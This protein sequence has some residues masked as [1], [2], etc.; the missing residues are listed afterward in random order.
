MVLLASEASTRHSNFNRENMFSICGL[1][2]VNSHPTRQNKSHIW[3]ALHL[4]KILNTP[5]LVEIVWHVALPGGGEMSHFA[6]GSVTSSNSMVTVIVPLSC[7]MAQTTSIF[8][9]YS[10]IIADLRNINSQSGP[11]NINIWTK[12]ILYYCCWLHEWVYYCSALCG[13]ISQFI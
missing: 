8:D 9:G 1:V 5:S 3:L 6:T 7:A 11:G 4:G 13:Q 12:R 10:C 2:Q